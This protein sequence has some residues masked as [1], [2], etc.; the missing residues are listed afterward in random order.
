MPVIQQVHRLHGKCEQLAAAF[1]IE[2]AHEALL[3]PVDGRPLHGGSV[4]ENEV[5]KH[6]LEIRA[7]EIGDVPEHALVSSGRRRLIERIHHLLERIGDHFVNAASALG[8]VDELVSVQIIVA[9]VLFADEIIHVAEPFRR[10]HCAAELRSQCEHQIDERAGEGREILRRV[11][12]AANGGIAV[13]QKRVQR[14]G[15]AVGFADNCCF[16]VA[17][18]FVLLQLTQIFFRQINAVQFT[19]L[20]IHRQPIQRDR[21]HLEQLRLQR[22]NVLPLHVRIGVDA[23]CGGGVFRLCVAVDELLV[24]CMVLVFVN[25][26]GMFSFHSASEWRL[27][28]SFAV[29]RFPIWERA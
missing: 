22:G 6:P 29:R 14:H 12:G 18:N 28:S 7:V 19:E 2:P 25:S 5:L 4:R 23:G 21:V 17:V 20:S 26:H 8:E 11:A 10:G 13:Q 24:A 16:I 9:A 27:D 15:R 1:L 3:Q